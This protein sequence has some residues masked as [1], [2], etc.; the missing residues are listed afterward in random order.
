[1]D[2]RTQAL[3]SWLHQCFPNTTFS[4]EPA[5]NDASFRRYFR[6]FLGEQ[7]WVA[8]D[9]PPDKEDCIPFIQI[10]RM[11]TDHGVHAPEILHQDLGQGFLLLSDLGSTWY[12]DVLNDQTV[13]ALYGDALDTLL[14]MQTIEVSDQSLPPYDEALLTREMDLFR[15]WFLA[16]FLEIQPDASLDSVWDALIQSALDQPKVFVHRD[17]HSRNLMHLA[18]RNPGVIDFQDAV[19]GPVTYDLASLLRDCYIAWPDAKVYGWVENVRQSCIEAGHVSDCSAETFRRWFDLMGVQRHLKAI[20]IF[21][22]LYLRDGKPG[23][24]KDMP[25]TLN[26]I[27]NLQGRYQELEPLL[28]FIRTHDVVAKL[29]LRLDS[30]PQA[31]QSS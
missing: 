16:D 22:R 19:H 18:D 4:M 7:T 28:D 24:L 14:H 20:G 5:S 30:L 6:V 29:H 26:Y 9:A 31:A 10:A 8:M 11:L 13:D 2:S 25:R 12:L 21:A 1:M 3:E 23:Y 15:D 17:Y 27:L